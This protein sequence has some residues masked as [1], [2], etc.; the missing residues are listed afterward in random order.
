MLVLLCG[1]V[2][3]D[4]SDLFSHEPLKQKNWSKQ[5]CFEPYG[6][7]PL[8]WDAHIKDEWDELYTLER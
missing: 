8:P 6:W 7:R 3:S 2:L 4:Q 5:A 1:S